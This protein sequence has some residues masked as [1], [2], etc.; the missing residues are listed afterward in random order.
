MYIVKIHGM[1]NCQLRLALINFDS[2]R[3]KKETVRLFT[4]RRYSWVKSNLA[5]GG[6]PG[7]FK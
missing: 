6:A 4:L 7:N 3:Q 2:V 5:L 1:S